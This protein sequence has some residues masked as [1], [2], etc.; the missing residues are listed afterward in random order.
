VQVYGL[1][2]KDEAGKYAKEFVRYLQRQSRVHIG[3]LKVVRSDGGGEFKTHDFRELVEQQGLLHQHSV[4][5]RSSQNG[6]ADRAIRTVSKMACAM[7]ID[8]QLPHYL[9]EDALRHVACIRNRLPQE[10]SSTAA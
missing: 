10:G 5:Y 2:T 8:S 7:L 9:W 1:K 6:V 4:R 3:E